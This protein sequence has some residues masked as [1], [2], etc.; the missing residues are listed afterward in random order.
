MQLK[1]LLSSKQ[2]RLTLC[3]SFNCLCFL[4]HQPN[5]AHERRYNAPTANEVAVIMPGSGNSETRREIVLHKRRGGLA[6]IHT[7]HRFYDALAYPLILPHAD[8]GWNL[9]IPFA[10][11]KPQTRQNSNPRRREKRVSCRQFYAHQLMVRKTGTI[12]EHYQVI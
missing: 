9:E 5:D 10:K 4:D 8:E 11:S 12:C 3:C 2:V 1:W 7:S 6:R